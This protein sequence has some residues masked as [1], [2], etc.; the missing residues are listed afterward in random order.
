MSGPEFSRPVPLARKNV[1]PETLYTGRPQHLDYA[2]DVL[3]S[4]LASAEAAALVRSLGTRSAI[5]APLIARGV[6]VGALSLFS[7]EP[8]RYGDEELTLL[9]DIAHRAALAVDNARVFRRANEAAQMRRD[10]VAVVAHDL[11]NPLNA[12]AMAAALIGKS[13]PP[14]PEGDRPRRQSSIITRASERMNRLIHDLLDVSAIDAGRLELEPQ[15]HRVGALVSEA[16]DAMAAMAQE[17][18]LTLERAVAAEVEALAVLADRDRLVQVFGNLVG[19][20]I[21]YTDAGGRI[22]L[23]AARA[24]D[25]VAFAVADDGPGIAAE[26]L[27][28]LFD[29][30]WRVRGRKRDGTGLGLWIVKGLVEAHGGRVSVDTAPGKGARF[31]FTVPLAP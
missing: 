1:L 16:I 7:P 29:R 13:A 28:Y 17:K 6:T 15:A 26:H 9:E 3:A 30:F 20:A 14:G 25:A 2:D 27:P 19:N 8:H 10:L 21:K 11:K 4:R 5:C 12:V 24:G 31:S 23:S 22:T 18:Q